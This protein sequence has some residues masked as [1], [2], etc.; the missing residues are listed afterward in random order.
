M[1]PRWR[2]GEKEGNRERGAGFGRD[3][4]GGNDTGRKKEGG[5]HYTKLTTK[6][7][8]STK[9]HYQVRILRYIRQMI[10][11]EYYKTK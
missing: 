10:I 2:H 3:S 5:R 1:D 7:T 11:T 4:K 6:I 8:S 9:Q